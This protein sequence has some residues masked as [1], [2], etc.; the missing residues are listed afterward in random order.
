MDKRQS[1]EEAAPHPDDGTQVIA[2]DLAYRRLPL[3]NVIF[4]GQP[5][6]GDRQ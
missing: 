3:V 1:P 6:A 4:F 5:K 2:P